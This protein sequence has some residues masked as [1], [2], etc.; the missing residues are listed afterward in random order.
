MKLVSKRRATAWVALLFGCSL[1][2]LCFSQ[3]SAAVPPVVPGIVID[4]IPAASGQFI[5]SPSIVI[6]TNGDYLASHDIFG[7]NSSSTN[8]AT[9]VIFRSADRGEKWQE[10]AQVRCS[11]WANLFVHRGVVY[12]MGVENEHGRIIIRRS[13]NGGTS[14]TEPDTTSTG[15]LTPTGHFHTAPVPV[16]EHAGKLWRAYEDADGGTEWGTRYRAGMLSVPVD[17]DLLNATNWSFSNSLQSNTNWLAGRFGGWLEGNAVVAPDGKVVDVL[18]VDTPGLPEKVAIAD[19]GDDGKR[20]SFNPDIAFVNFPG[21]AK[22]FTIRFDAKSDCY[23]SVASIVLPQDEKTGRSG[24]IRNTLA[25]IRSHDLH[26]WMVRAILL[27]YPDIK[28]HGFQYADWQLDGDDIIAVVRTAF[29]DA[30]G[31]AHTYHDA[32]FLTFYRWINFRK[33]TTDT[34]GK[35][36]PH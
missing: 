17:S 2:F 34:G 35:G 16:I 13:L 10:I 32:N 22:K 15:L 21:G 14:W 9:T 23:W 3:A 31:G 36:N 4:H 26:H 28:K 12:L 18:R 25:L 20:I 30:Q 7:P 29:D 8:C 1:T 27:H 6:L 5:G 24:S 11:F 19:V 33:L